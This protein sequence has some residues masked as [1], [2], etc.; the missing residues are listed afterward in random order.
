MK[1]YTLGDLIRKEKDT[2][3][4]VRHRLKEDHEIEYSRS[5][6]SDLCNDRSGYLPS[7]ETFYSAVAEIL[8]KNVKVKDVRLAFKKNRK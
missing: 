2:L 3:E 5:Q 6:F 7:F 4:R 8:G 1:E